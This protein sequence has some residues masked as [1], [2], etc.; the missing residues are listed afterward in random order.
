[1]YFSMIFIVTL[2]RNDAVCP[3]S[4]QHGTFTV[5]EADNTDHNLSAS[6]AQTSFHRT[7]LFLMQFTSNSSEYNSESE[8]S[9][10]TAA[11]L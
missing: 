6:T 11:F 8:T 5:A 4:L 1:M 9:H 7:T 2:Q 10:R 3:L